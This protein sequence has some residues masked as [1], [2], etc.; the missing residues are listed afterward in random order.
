M[1]QSAKVPPVKSVRRPSGEE[2]K[3]EILEAAERT[4]GRAGYWSATTAQIAAAVGITQPALYRYFPSKR[5]LFIE[6]VALRQSELEGRIIEAVAGG[7]TAL[8]KL[9]RLSR[10]TT[11][12]AL[13]HPDMARLRIQAVAVAAQDEEIRDGVN[14]TLDALIGGHERLLTAAVEEGS[15]EAP[16]DIHS[17]ACSIAG[18]AFLLYVALSTEHEMAQAGVVERTMEGFL[19]VLARDTGS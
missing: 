2:R 16:P 4:F 6:A 19:R 9:R 17:A 11:A 8:D 14:A 18:M 7:G 15:I 10:S 1:D 5:Q 12:Y 3:R 13:E